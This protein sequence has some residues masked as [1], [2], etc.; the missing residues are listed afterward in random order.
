MELHFG[1]ISQELSIENVI[2]TRVSKCMLCL[3]TYEGKT[4]VMLDRVIQ[5]LVLDSHIF[6]LVV[7]ASMV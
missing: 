5:L 4:L 6:N 2:Y 7:I 3:Y 1:L